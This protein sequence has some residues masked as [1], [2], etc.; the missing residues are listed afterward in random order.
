MELDMLDKLD[1]GADDWMDFLTDEGEVD[2]DWDDDVPEHDDPLWDDWDIRPDGSAGPISRPE[3]AGVLPRLDT[4]LNWELI[5]LRNLLSRL[6]DGRLQ[7]TKEPE[8]LVL[9]VIRVTDAIL[10]VL[11][12]D[13][14][15]AGPPDNPLQTALDQ[16]LKEL[17]LSDEQ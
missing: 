16:V 10:R 8:A 9:P 13:R 7:N 2:E 6:T 5:I 12:A 15:L 4:Q 11:R 3:S 17:G 14:H 1:I